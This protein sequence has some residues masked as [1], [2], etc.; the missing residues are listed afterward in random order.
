MLVQDQKESESGKGREA[1]PMGWAWP[2]GNR[3][4]VGGGRKNLRPLSSTEEVSANVKKPEPPALR[5]EMA[6]S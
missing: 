5:G 6:W 4:E 2:L 1:P 3:G